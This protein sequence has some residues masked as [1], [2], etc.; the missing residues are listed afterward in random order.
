VK[1][2]N[3]KR[4]SILKAKTN[5]QKRQGG[6]GTS[7]K[8]KLKPRS[9]T[10]HQWSEANQSKRA[11]G[12]LKES[13]VWKRAHQWQ[14]P[15]LRWMKFEL[16]TKLSPSSEYKIFIKLTKGRPLMPLS[17]QAILTPWCKKSLMQAVKYLHIKW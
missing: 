5:A 8:S 16:F 12:I 10:S 4:G 14:E 9:S 11:E 2:R 7:L 17:D 1:G 6:K 3:T 15:I 13:Q